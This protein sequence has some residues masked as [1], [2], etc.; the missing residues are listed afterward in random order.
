MTQKELAQASNVSQ[1]NISKFENGTYIPS[2]AVLQ[3]IADGMGTRLTLS[4]EN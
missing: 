1:A 3:R 2:L 4:L